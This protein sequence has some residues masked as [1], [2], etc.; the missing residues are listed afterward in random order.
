MLEIINLH[1]TIEDQ[2]ILRGLSLRIG[3]GDIYA[4]M[5]P[6]G[7]GKST[8]AR[9]LA[10][11]SAY[12]VT[13]GEILFEGQNILELPPEERARLGIFMGFQYPTEIPGVSNIQFLQASLNAV[14]A[15]RGEELFEWRSI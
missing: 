4:I 14:R 13:E 12:E 6:N 3:K 1:V 7:A 9:V 15:S 2:P 11:D 8:L 10:G 5:G